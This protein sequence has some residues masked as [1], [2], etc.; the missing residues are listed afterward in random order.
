MV[1]LDADDG[2]AAPAG[3]ARHEL[4]VLA[5]L[6]GAVLVTVAAASSDGAGRRVVLA[7]VVAVAAAAGSLVVRGIRRH[8]PTVAVVWWS[9]ATFTGAVALVSLAEALRGTALLATGVADV[10]AG[11]ATAAGYLAGVAATSAVIVTT[12]RAAGEVTAVSVLLG[13]TVA[14]AAVG[15]LATGHTDAWLPGGRTSLG[16]LLGLMSAVAAAGVAW[17]LVTRDVT[18]RSDVHLAAAVALIAAGESGRAFFADATA[19]RDVPLVA[20]CAG[21]ACLAFAALHPSMA[22]RPYSRDVRTVIPDPS[23][24]PAVGPWTPEGARR[25]HPSS[26]T[27][28]LAEVER[29]VRRNEFD[30]AYQP[31]VRLADGAPV[32][33]EAL[34]RWWHPT[35][36]L[37]RPDAFIPAIERLGRMDLVS[38]WVAARVARDLPVLLPQLSGPDAYVTLNVSP[39]QLADPGF[40]ERLLTTIRTH[41]DE[42]DVIVIEITERG[43]FPA[44]RAAHAAVDALQNE[45]VL[46][47]IDDFGVGYANLARLSQLDPDIVKLDRDLVH[48]VCAP[49][50]SSLLQ[51]TVGLLR[52]MGTLVI[53]EGIEQADEWE[54]LRRLGVPYGQ[55]WLFGRPMPLSVFAAVA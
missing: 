21:L 40:S 31:I 8:R 33:A 35:R 6:V 55:G 10:A 44:E 9:L 32:G 42:V 4:V 53:A 5:S 36:G 30:L 20:T 34:L 13:V 22:G 38:D 50:G 24:S 18:S 28:L 37:V 3:T 23:P 48:G 54:T 2:R 45:G 26:G 15:W 17:L 27:A 52:Q 16:V 46:V 12:A 39:M 43:L 14:A 11:L 49:R 7:G 19:W 51:A 1:S 47:A 29:A 25:R 41:T